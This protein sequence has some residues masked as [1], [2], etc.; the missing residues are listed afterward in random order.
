MSDAHHSKSLTVAVFRG[1]EE[2]DLTETIRFRGMVLL[3][4]RPSGKVS[5]YGGMLHAGVVQLF[6]QASGQFG[7]QLQ[8]VGKLGRNRGIGER[9]LGLQQQSGDGVAQVAF[10]RAC[11]GAFGDSLLQLAAAQRGANFADQDARIRRWRS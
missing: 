7:H 10:K 9:E 11:G 2:S 3:L 8:L 1:S 6:A 4:P 5:P